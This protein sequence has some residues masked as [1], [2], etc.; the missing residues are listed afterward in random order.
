MT[1]DGRPSA[2]LQQ[3]EQLRSDVTRL[4]DAEQRSRLIALAGVVLGVL[5]VALA[6]AALLG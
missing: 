3:V 5:S 4:R 6:V 1:A 2:I